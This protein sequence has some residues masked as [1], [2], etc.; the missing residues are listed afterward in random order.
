MVLA[1]LTSLGTVDDRLDACLQHMF[2]PVFHGAMSTL[3]G[4]NV[5]ILFRKMIEFR[6]NHAGVLPIRFRYHLFL[7]HDV[8]P[9]LFGSFQR[10][11]SIAGYFDIHW[12]VPRGNF[13]FL[14]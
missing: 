3:L 5:I 1:F 11:M 12:A 4:K 6:H 13:I 10:T 7:L 14:S 2:V 8:I 9:G